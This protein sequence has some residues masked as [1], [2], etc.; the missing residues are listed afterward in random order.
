MSISLVSNGATVFGVGRRVEALQEVEKTLGGERGK[1]IV[2]QGDITSKEGIEAIFKVISEKT[3]HVDV[4][5]NNAGIVKAIPLAQDPSDVEETVEKLMDS[6]FQDFADVNQVNVTAPYFVTIRFL[7]LLVKSKSSPVV[8]FNASSAAHLITTPNGAIYPTSKSAALHMSRIL[9]ARLIPFNVR[10]N[11]FL[12]GLFQSP[13]TGDLT[14]QAWAQDIIDNNTPAD[15][16]GLIL[17]LC[18]KAGEYVSGSSVTFDG[19]LLLTT[20]G[21]EFMPA[22]LAKRAAH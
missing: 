12:L 20:S 10:V 8:L 21:Q 13:L 3:D 16:A 17:F 4:L 5:I 19:G 14:T 22:V 18:S 6:S 15:L 9:A 2:I 11:S 7:P 1:F